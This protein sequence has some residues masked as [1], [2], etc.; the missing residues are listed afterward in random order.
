MSERENAVALVYAE[1]LLA[2]LG[3]QASSPLALAETHPALRWSRSG[4]MALTGE[5]DTPT[6]FPA[7]LAACADAAL[8]ALASLAPAGALDGIDAAQLLAER[9]AIAGHVRAGAISPGGACRLLQAADGWIALNLARDDDWELLP[10]WLEAE[11]SADWDSVASAV[12]AREVAPLIEQGHLLGLA[13]ANVNPSPACGRGAGEG[14]DPRGRA[15]HGAIAEERGSVND[16]WMTIAQ[17]Y[18]NP[19]SPP[20]SRKRERGAKEAPRVLDLSSLWAGPLCGHLLHKLGADVV[21][22]ESTQRPDGARNG[23]L[24]FFNLLNAGKRSVALDLRSEEGRAQLRALIAAADIVI[25]ASRPRALRQMGFD[26]EALAREHG[27]TWISLSGHG[28]GEPQEQWIAYGDD[29]AVAAGLTAILHR[30]TGQQ[31]IVGDAIA[32]PLTGLH[33]ALAAWSGWLQGGGRLVSLAL[34]EVVQHCLEFDLPNDAALR[35]RQRAWTALAD[36]DGGARAPVARKASGT[37]PALGAHTD[38]VL[39]E[40][41]HPC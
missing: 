7:P 14:M 1:R 37:A 11:V 24:D 39:A 19:L 41:T 36:R 17:L 12:K 23:P 32:D 34:R 33:A 35:E 22:L 20:L 18:R 30:A 31:L 40:W 13:L 21:K 26:A 2:Q 3:Q 15:M 10:A 38:E 6:M 5:P 16:G 9:A 4:L 8:A 27:L 28:R 29:A 25:E